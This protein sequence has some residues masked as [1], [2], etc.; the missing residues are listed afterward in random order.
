MTRLILATAVVLGLSELAPARAQYF[1][2]PFYPPGYRYSSAHGS[3]FGFSFGGPKFRVSG[4][5]GG[6]VKRSA[7]FA[8]PVF[9]APV[10]PFGPFGPVGFAPVGFGAPYFGGWGP[11]F[12]GYGPF[13]PPVVA[14][15]VPVPIVVGGNPPEPIVNVPPPPNV[16]ALFPRGD[17]LVI[18]PQRNGIPE[19]IPL[20]LP[21]PPPRVGMFDPVAMPVLVEVADPDPKK[22]A[23]RLLKLGRAAFAAGDFGRA[24]EHFERAS[25]ADPADAVAYFLHGQAKF[26]TGQFAEA[27]ARI[28]DGLARDPK[29]PLAA[30]DP[31][32]LY[33]DQPERFVLHLIALKKAAAANPNQVT[34]EF[35]L[36]YQLWYTGDKAEANRLFRAAEARLPDPGP[37]ALFKLP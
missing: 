3:G 14:V 1:G 37:F 5:S 33:G 19:P 7:V 18:A 23:L 10:A 30:F 35:L 9:V 36:G 31:I 13:G 28:R 15:P 24:A 8:P 25:T 11:G 16:P 27:A 26:A 17:F 32:A 6:F 34:L 21:P 4:F 29:W 2:G 22:E 12:G 20:P